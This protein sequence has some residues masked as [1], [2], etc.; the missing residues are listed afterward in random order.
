MQ[1]DTKE[2][3]IL[4]LWPVWGAAL[5]VRTEHS[6]QVLSLVILHLV[7]ECFKAFESLNW[8]GIKTH[9]NYKLLWWCAAVVHQLF[10]GCSRLKSQRNPPQSWAPIISTTFHHTSYGPKLNCRVHAFVLAIVISSCSLEEKVFK[11]VNELQT[12]YL[13]NDIFKFVLRKFRMMNY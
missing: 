6:M 1:D 8:Q 4:C 10:C 7:L 11:K 12:F 13:Q 9:A 2:H 5:C 3:V